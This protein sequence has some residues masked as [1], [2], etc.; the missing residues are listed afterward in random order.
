MYEVQIPTR[1]RLFSVPSNNSVTI[2]KYSMAYFFHIKVKTAET[3]SVLS[4]PQ[5]AWYIY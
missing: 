4:A 5:L 3:V 2:F 1:K